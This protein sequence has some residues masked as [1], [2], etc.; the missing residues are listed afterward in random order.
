MAFAKNYPE[1]VDSRSN[2]TFFMS[3]NIN[4]FTIN[5]LDKRKKN[6]I[7]FDD[8]EN[9]KDQSIIFDFF[10]VGRH[11]NCSPIYLAHE[12]YG[13]LSTLRSRVS[14]FILFN[15]SKDKLSRIFNSINLPVDKKEFYDIARNTWANSREKK[16]LFFNKESNELLISPF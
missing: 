4:D 5:K 14:Q 1:S 8:C 7:I 2:I 15:T 9:S 6:L 3:D 16:Y 13:N 12:F 11:K 10:Q